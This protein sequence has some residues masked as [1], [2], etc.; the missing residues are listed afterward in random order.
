MQPLLLSWMVLARFLGFGFWGLR[1]LGFLGLRGLRSLGLVVEFGE[2]GVSGPG[3]QVVGFV[4]K[5]GGL[6]RV[7][8]TCRTYVLRSIEVRSWVCTIRCPVHILVSNPLI[9][10]V[11]G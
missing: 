9:R 2:C 1:S 6:S 7:V 4:L 8:S 5:G 3:F 11:R 10:S